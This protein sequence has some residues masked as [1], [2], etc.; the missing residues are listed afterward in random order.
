MTVIVGALNGTLDSHTFDLRLTDHLASI[1][2][3]LATLLSV[4]KMFVT[5]EHPCT[6]NNTDGWHSKLRKL[7]GKAQPNMYKAVTLFQSE[8][9]V[10][11][12]SL[13][14]AA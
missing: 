10:T 11:E 5:L 6:N 3:F 14:H 12:S 4:C 9:A 1:S 8:Q 7:A 2:S 13:M